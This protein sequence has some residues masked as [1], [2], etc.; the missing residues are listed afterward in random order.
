[1]AKR[2]ITPREEPLDSTSFLYFNKKD[3]KFRP[4]VLVRLTDAA[5]RDRRGTIGIFLQKKR[6][7]H[8]RR[9]HDRTYEILFGDKKILCCAFELEL[10]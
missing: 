8:R 1:M 10:V 5:G 2:L 7:S 3:S 9:V 6:T 4:G